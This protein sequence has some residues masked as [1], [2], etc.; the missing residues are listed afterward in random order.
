MVIPMEYPEA[1]VTDKEVIEFEEKFGFRLPTDYR[2]FLLEHN[3]ATSLS[4]DDRE[5]VRLPQIRN[6]REMS[7]SWFA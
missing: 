6:D 7:V 4:K 1:R 3:G 5:T 2:G